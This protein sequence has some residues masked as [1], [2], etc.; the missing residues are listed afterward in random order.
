MN[1]MAEVVK[2]LS[3]KKDSKDA[4]K[5]VNCWFFKQLPFRNYD[6]VEFDEIKELKKEIR[7]LAIQNLKME[8][9]EE[10]LRLE[11]EKFCKLIRGMEETFE[12]E[13]VGYENERTNLRILRENDH[14]RITSLEKEVQNL[15]RALICLDRIYDDTFRSFKAQVR[16]LKIKLEVESAI[17]LEKSEI[18]R[19]ANAN[20]QKLSTDLK[21]SEDECFSLRTII[22]WCKV[23]DKYKR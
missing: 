20:L 23:C 18:S 22:R 4:N 14:G 10:L 5:F 1:K 17:V 3:L 16:S 15:K 13:M 19:K 9:R 12:C 2:K 21:K 11:R 7:T 8:N 6:F